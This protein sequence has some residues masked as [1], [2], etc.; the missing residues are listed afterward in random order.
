MTWMEE[1]HGKHADLPTD[2]LVLVSASRFT[3]CELT[4]NHA[5]FTADGTE[6]GR[7]ADLIERTHQTSLH[8]PAQLSGFP[9]RREVRKACTSCRRRMCSWSPRSSQSS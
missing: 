2:R 4:L 6:A 1:M 5:L 7:S 8:R 9:V 3:K